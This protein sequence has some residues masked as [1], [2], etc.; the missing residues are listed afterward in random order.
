MS[1]L[2]REIISII[3]RQTELYEEFLGLER[4]KTDCIS[5]NLVTELEGIVSD[6][7]KV[8]GQIE[9]IESSRLS[10]V[11]K[12]TG[13][14]YINKA[15]PSLRDI[16]QYADDDSGKEMIL[17]AERLKKI[18]NEL[19][20]ILETNARMIKDNMNFYS[21]IVE[22]IKDS[23]DDKSAYSAGRESRVK[24]NSVLINRTV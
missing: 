23:L 18:T 7:D 12:I 6:Q 1:N 10:C 11:R 4:K 8:I 20:R 3:D 24:K 9:L 15:N 13:K 16:S 19:Q 5:G 22:G 21:L 17:C 14:F 2:F